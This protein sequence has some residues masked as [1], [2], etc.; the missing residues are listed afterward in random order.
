MATCLNVNLPEY[1][2]LK[3]VY[4]TDVDTANV[5]NNWQ[6]LNNVDTFPTVLEAQDFVSNQKLAFSL[7]QRQFSD[8]LLN[9]LRRERIGHSYQG[10]FYVNNS[11]PTTREYDEMYLASNLKR[12]KRYLQINNIPENRVTLERTA[13]T[14]RVTVNEDMFSAK[15]MIES[16][17]SWDTPRARAVVMHLKRMFPQINVQMLSVSQA[18]QMY[19]GFPEWKKN[20]VPFDQMRSFYVDGVAYLIKGR[21]TDEVAI[22]EMLHPFVD[23]IKIDNEGLFN[24]LLAEARSNF[25]EMVQEIEDSYNEERSFNDVERDL[26]IVTQAL[27]CLLYT[28]DAADE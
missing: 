14:Y 21:V 18:R 16:S 7:R 24:S 19:E 26:E 10:S 23:A 4:K 12:L 11:N 27:S 2:A 13:K 17:R 25:P 6:K 15:D 9:N 28:S 8:A 5:V 22:E 20:N 1:K 3:D